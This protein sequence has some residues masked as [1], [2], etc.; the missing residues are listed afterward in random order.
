[1]EYIK[2]IEWLKENWG[3]IIS[4]FSILA[5]LGLN[6]PNIIKLVSWII[7]KYK[8]FIEVEIEPVNYEEMPKDYDREA[9]KRVHL[10]MHFYNK[11][12][13]TIFIKE[14]YLVNGYDLRGTWYIS[15][16]KENFEI[17]KDYFNI[18]ECVEITKENITKDKWG[19]FIFTLIFKTID[20]KYDFC[21]IRATEGVGGSFTYPKLKFKFNHKSIRKIC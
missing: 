19:G 9:Y 2:I 3:Y 6:I 18:K 7:N 11:S 5:L 15:K 1:M 8:I 20:G 17:P 21:K 13:K 16:I 4:I 10:N 12:N 14:L